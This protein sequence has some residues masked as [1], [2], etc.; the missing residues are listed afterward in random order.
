MAQK[1]VR[2]NGRWVT[3][4]TKTGKE[5][6]PGTNIG[7]AAR[8]LASRL[9]RLPG[10]MRTQA[11]H[12]R[13]DLRDNLTYSDKTDKK[14]RPLT[15][16]QVK[17]QAAKNKPKPFQ[18]PGG[19]PNGS[20]QGQAR[21]APPAPKLPPKP[22]RKPAAAKPTVKPAPKPT[23]T[24]SSTPSKKSKTSTYKAH[25]SD[26][27]IGRHKTLAE[28]RAAVAKGKTTTT[29]TNKPTPP[30]KKKKTWLATN[31]RPNK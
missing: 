23:P 9:R 12:A 4:D 19:N 27:H 8:G 26:L 16:A 30:K 1:K 18:G 10:D 3:I 7:N 21:Q 20:G 25:G 15:P 24:P 2:R 17:A 14:G 11:R 6:K 5:I 22:T 29:T 31:Y 28:H 13:N